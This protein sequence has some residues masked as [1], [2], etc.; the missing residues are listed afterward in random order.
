MFRLLVAR[1]LV[2]PRRRLVAA[3]DHR[4]R[5]RRAGRGVIS[6]LVYVL[7]ATAR[8]AQVGFF[9][10]GTTIPL[11]RDSAFGRGYSDLAVILVAL[12]VALAAAIRIDRPEREST[13]RSPSW[14]RSSCGGAAGSA[15]LVPGL[16]AMRASTRRAARGC[17]WTGRTCSPARCGSVASSGCSSLRGAQGPAGGVHDRRGPA[18]SRTALI[19]TLVLI[20]SGT[21]QAI[22]RLRRCRRCGTRATGRR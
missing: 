8:F 11:V 3:R 1:P 2:R 6:T 5:V 22:L 17:C 14:A 15:L 21:V 20:A 18:F 16:A 10:L 4:R 9:D 19:A 12:G 13:A 7:A